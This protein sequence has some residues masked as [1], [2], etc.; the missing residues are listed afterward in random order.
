MEELNS[1]QD[2]SEEDMQQAQVDFQ[3]RMQS[4]GQA[5]N[6]QLRQK[7]D[8][9]VANVINEKGNIDV[10]LDSSKTNPQVFMGGVDLTD[11][12]IQKLQ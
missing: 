5:Y 1:K 2:V 6:T 4:V 7:L 10:V 3:R 9:A 12:V 11:E 8:A